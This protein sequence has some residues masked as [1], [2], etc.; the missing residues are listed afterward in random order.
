VQASYKRC[1]FNDL[2]VIKIADPYPL[3]KLASAGK[4]G[5][6]TPRNHAENIGFSEWANRE[7]LNHSL[8]WNGRMR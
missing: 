8:N 2:P 7:K 3:R 5:L 1:E 4:I 6:N